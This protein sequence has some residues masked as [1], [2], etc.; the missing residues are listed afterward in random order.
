MLDTVLLFAAQY[1]GVP[2]LGLVVVTT[3]VGG[4]L[5]AAGR[6]NIKTRTAEESGKRRLVNHALGQSNT[7]EGSKAVGI[8]WMRV[9]MGIG[10]IMFGVVF[11]LVDPM[12]AWLRTFF[13]P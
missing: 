1:P 11:G 9:I 10:V 6:N 5:I 13:S 8:G 4:L 12:L 3:A 7:Y 2:R